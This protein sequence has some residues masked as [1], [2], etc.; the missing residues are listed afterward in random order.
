MN[1]ALIFKNELDT[2]LEILREISKISSL[3]FSE[4]VFA[5][6][7]KERIRD[8]GYEPIDAPDPSG[9]SGIGVINSKKILFT[10][11]IDRIRVSEPPKLIINEDSVTG[12]LDNI[13][14]VGILLYLLENKETQAS[15]LFT[16]QEECCRNREQ[17]EGFVKK[18]LDEETV[19]IDVDIDP[20]LDNSELT[21]KISIRSSDSYKDYSPE[22]YGLLR[23]S[24]DMEDI[25]WTDSA[26]WLILQISYLGLKNPLGFAGL[27]I[28]NYHSSTEIC[29]KEA[30][31]NLFK[32]VRRAG[33][34]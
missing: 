30:F 34:L 3:T 28:L 22:A 21:E 16:T 20:V 23:E 2:L 8:A 31:Y 13:I 12:Q 24:A 7:L 27:P 32:V 18:Y 26:A 19:L 1:N 5:S 17:I 29:R 15:I 9:V 11:H 10:A 25:G 14:G 33:S 4:E 6:Y